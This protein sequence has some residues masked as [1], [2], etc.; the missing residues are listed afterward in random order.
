MDT[1]TNLANQVELGH[2]RD[3]SRSAQSR[4]PER[5][6]QNNEPY[7]YILLASCWVAHM[8]GT[9]K[10]SYLEEPLNVVLSITFCISL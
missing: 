8:H 6:H 10:V 1:P 3:Q 7:Q 9:H 5:A 2:A 4:G